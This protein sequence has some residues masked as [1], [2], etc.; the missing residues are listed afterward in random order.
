M[1]G[2]SNLSVMVDNVTY[3]A[4]EFHHKA[5]KKSMSTA[6]RSLIREICEEHAL[7]TSFRSLEIIARKDNRDITGL[8]N[9]RVAAH[10]KV[11]V[12]QFLGMPAADQDT[13]LVWARKN[14]QNVFP[15]IISLLLSIDTGRL[16][17]P[18]APV[19]FKAIVERNRVVSE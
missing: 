13:Y 8:M 17:P 12:D 6:A 15:A 14:T 5:I 18:L 7:P 3:E 9:L 16:L 2:A 10:C 19:E 4:L 1:P 11:R